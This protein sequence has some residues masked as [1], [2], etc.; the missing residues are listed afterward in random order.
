MSAKHIHTA[1]SRETARC[2]D[3]KKT[4]EGMES[5]DRGGGGPVALFLMTPECDGNVVNEEG[6][7]KTPCF[8]RGDKTRRGGRSL[9]HAVSLT[10]F[11]AGWEKKK[12]EGAARGAADGGS[13]G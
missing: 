3:E 11:A 8:P 6:W 5:R 2:G 10:H 12:I 13:V 1:A 9:T 4:P 7:D